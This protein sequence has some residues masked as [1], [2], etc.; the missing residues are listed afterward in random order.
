MIIIFSSR[1]LEYQNAR[2]PWF[3]TWRYSWWW[4]FRIFYW[5]WKFFILTYLRM[6]LNPFFESYFQQRFIWHSLWWSIFTVISVFI[7]TGPIKILTK[8][9]FLQKWVLSPP[10]Y[11]SFHPTLK[12]VFSSR[13]Y[14]ISEYIQTW[15]VQY[16]LFFFEIVLPPFYRRSTPP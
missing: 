8:L 2:M 14:N 7:D 4:Q 5:K 1:C 13:E 10:Q 3:F 11:V 15:N 6:L 12:T 9:S 16:P